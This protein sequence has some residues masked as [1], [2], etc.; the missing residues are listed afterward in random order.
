MSTWT[1]DELRGVGEAE[2]LQ[3]AVSRRDGTLRKPLPIWV[4]R[5]GDKLYVRSYRRQ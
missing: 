2:E 3:N 4:L 1:S 5:V